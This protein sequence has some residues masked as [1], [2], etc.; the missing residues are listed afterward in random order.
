M[1]SI[2]RRL[3]VAPILGSIWIAKIIV[4]ADERGAAV[5]MV[6]G[7]CLSDRITFIDR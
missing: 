1:C 7:R 3:I 6:L 4:N 5:V 2:R